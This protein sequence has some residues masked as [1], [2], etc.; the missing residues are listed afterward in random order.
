[1]KILPYLFILMVTGFFLVE[2]CD[3]IEPPYRESSTVTIGPNDS[4]VI[5]SGDTIVFPHDTTTDVKKVLAEDYTGHFCGNCPYAGYLLN[6]TIKPVFG[7][8]LVVISVHA[9]YFATTC[10][11]G[12]ACPG[13]Q[14]PGSFT[15][16]LTCAEGEDWNHFFGLDIA[17]NPNGLIDRKD[18]P[19]SHIKGKDTWNSNIQTESVKTPTI[20]I[21]IINHYDS[22]SH[23]LKAAIQS[24]FISSISATY[25]LQ[26]LLTEDSIID[27]QEW[28]APHVPQWDGN[29]IHHHV[30]RGSLNSHYGEQ[31]ATGTIS[32]GKIDARGYTFSLN[33]AW[34]AKNC[35]VVAF[36]Y[37]ASNYYVTQVEE[38]D[39]I[40]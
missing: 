17:G 18:Y 21:R 3:K 33:P 38:A 35:K 7:N 36:V 12:D 39:V 24:K 29:Y 8:K 5:I 1:M 30:L 37:D 31:I 14:P 15:T 22:T 20:K 11:N 32:S 6:D 23:E 16:D 4:T 13:N 26:V 10:P 34:K 40:Q 9:G 25:K 19:G 28:Y 27:W 2:S